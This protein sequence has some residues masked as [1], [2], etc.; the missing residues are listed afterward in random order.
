MNI[1]NGLGNSSKPTLNTTMASFQNAKESLHQNFQNGIKQ[2]QA[3]ADYVSGV[4]HSG[5][6]VAADIAEKAKDVILPDAWGFQFFNG[7]AETCKGKAKKDIPGLLLDKKI[8]CD[9]H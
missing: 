9:T 7:P 6:E 8:F 2:A 5:L 3:I 4:I 1:I